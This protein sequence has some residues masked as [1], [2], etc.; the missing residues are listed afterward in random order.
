MVIEEIS[1]K[2]RSLLFSMST[3][4]PPASAPVL[5][6]GEVLADVFP[7]RSVLGGAPFNVACHLSAF[8]MNPLFITCTGYDPLQEE[9]LLRMH[10]LG[11]NTEG[12]QID[13]EYPTGQVDVELNAQGSHRFIIKADQAY[14]HIDAGKAIAFAVQHQP[15][16]FYF[17]TL[18]QRGEVSRQA[19]RALQELLN[20]KRMS[21]INLRPP[22]FDLDITVQTLAAA[23]VVK[24]SR[25]ELDLL[26]QELQLPGADAE[27]WARE[28]AE[29]YQLE[30]LLITCGA[31]G[32][33]QWQ[34]DKAILKA[35]PAGSSRPIVDTIGAG[36]AFSAVILLGMLN[37]WPDPLSLAR[38]NT[39]ARSICGIRGAL[40]AD[41]A[42]YT[43]FLEAWYG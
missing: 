6:F 23:D 2:I 7:E 12:V 14:D 1:F 42:F 22:W 24:M 38:A 40:P 9:L 25:E 11:M 13:A 26:A 39:F 17:G 10:Q 32:A 30:R 29:R 20:C 28:L 21:D 41:T 3:Q 43:P 27:Q 33:W 18:A 36:D 8:V 4:N 37:N 5:I 35:R 31:D 34:P 19:L 16:L 15:Q